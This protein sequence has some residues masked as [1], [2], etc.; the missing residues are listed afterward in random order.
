MARPGRHAWLLLPTLIALGLALAPTPA[1]AAGC[2]APDRPVLGLSP[3]WDQPPA[4]AAPRPADP[5]RLGRLP[6]SQEIPGSAPL[7]AAIADGAPLGETVEMIPAAS[8]PRFE[9]AS[10]PLHAT[11]HSAV[12]PR[13]PRGA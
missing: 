3:D 9:A 5:A 10:A 6:C 8:R 12:R 13:P 4:T 11:H 2:H 7:A 1:A